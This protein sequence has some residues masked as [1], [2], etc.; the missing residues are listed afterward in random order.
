[1]TFFY[2]LQEHTGMEGI[3]VATTSY[4]LP[5]LRT[6]TA[7]KRQSLLQGPHLQ[8]CGLVSEEGR[9]GERAG[10][11]GMGGDTGLCFLKAIEGNSE[12][13]T[14]NYSIHTYLK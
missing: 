11:G 2:C 7:S 13:N 8:E 5:F 4:C 12:L 14:S 6:P 1:M 9:G 3:P 10:L